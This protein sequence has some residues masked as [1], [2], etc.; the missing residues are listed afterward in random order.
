MYKNLF[1]FMKNG[2]I[3]QRF[4]FPCSTYAQPL[5]VSLVYLWPSSCALPLQ[6]RAAPSPSLWT[7]RLRSASWCPAPLSTLC[8]A[9]TPTTSPPCAPPGPSPLATPGTTRTSSRSCRYAR[10]SRRMFG[11]APPREQHPVEGSPP[12]LNMNMTYSIGIKYKEYADMQHS[13]VL[14]N[15]PRWC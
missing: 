2:L 3:T 8:R 4:P 15:N 5:G 12:S 1:T 6:P 13:H 14:F 11:G 9:P 7:W 10:G